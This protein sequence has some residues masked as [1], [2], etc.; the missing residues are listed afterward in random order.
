MGRTGAADCGAGCIVGSD[1]YC[2]ERQNHSTPNSTWQ[3]MGWTLTGQRQDTPIR[4]DPQLSGGRVPC[5]LGDPWVWGTYDWPY[6]PYHGQGPALGGGPA[7]RAGWRPLCR[8]S[9]T[10]GMP[11]PPSTGRAA[12]APGGSAALP[13]FPR[14]REAA[15]VLSSSGSRLRPDSEH[16]VRLALQ[17]DTQLGALCALGTDPLTSWPNSLGSWRRHALLGIV[18][19]LLL[20]LC[21]CGVWTQCACTLTTKVPHGKP[22]PQ[23]VRGDR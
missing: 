7:S 8:L 20:S 18:G 16:Q 9:P 14:R 6:L 13:P 3:R 19:L 17:P 2:T 4:T 1:P 12:R 23:A 5:P 21:A 10:T 22:G 15:P 11:T